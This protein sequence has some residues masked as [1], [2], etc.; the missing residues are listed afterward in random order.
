MAGM[1][2]T[3]GLAAARP[4]SEFLRLL[5]PAPVGVEATG[6]MGRGV[7]LDALAALGVTRPA[8]VGVLRPGLAGLAAMGPDSFLP[9]VLGALT[10]VCSRSGRQRMLDQLGKAFG[11]SRQLVQTSQ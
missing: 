4:A 8:A 5:G 3:G 11:S 7:A 2:A 10:P 6:V 9:A 1:T